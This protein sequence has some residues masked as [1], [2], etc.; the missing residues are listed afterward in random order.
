[1]SAAKNEAAAE[2]PG[3]PSPP[4]FAAAAQPFLSV[5]VT[6]HDR[7]AYLRGAIESLLAQSLAPDR[8]EVLVVKNYADPTLD[9]FLL[10]SGTNHWVTKAGP[11]SQKLIEA[12]GRARGRVVTFLEDDDLYAPERLAAVESAF[13]AEPGLGFFRNGFEAIDETGRRYGGPLP[14][15]LRRSRE[16]ACDLLVREPEKEAEYRRLVDGL[17]DFNTSTMAIRRDLL[18][19]VLPLFARIG[20]GADRFLFCTALALPCSLRFDRRPLTRYRVHGGNTGVMTAGE[21]DRLG[22]VDRIM[23]SNRADEPVLY[24]LLRRSPRRLAA[25][26]CEG[27]MLVN[28]IYAELRD[29]SVDRRRMARLLRGLP[30]HRDTPSVR[31]NRRLVL[32]GLAYL[33]FPSTARRVHRRRLGRPAL[34][35]G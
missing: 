16:G 30:A 28:E 11:L 22:L 33:L 6:A 34:V 1:M 17:P 25:H 35:P 7:R 3:T 32:E 26:D 27:R 10:A 9:R 24:E 29:R 21:S 18:E 12:L 13:R 19:Q 31:A 4:R 5:V 20:S 23:A 15:A 8:F 14:D 2:E